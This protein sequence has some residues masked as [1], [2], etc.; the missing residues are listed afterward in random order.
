MTYQS[1]LTVGI[2]S[3]YKFL[4]P[5]DYRK[6]MVLTNIWLILGEMITLQIIYQDQ[7]WFWVLLKR[8]ILHYTAIFKY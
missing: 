3:H 2:Y 6:E 8:S 5:L 4:S 7:K 1:P